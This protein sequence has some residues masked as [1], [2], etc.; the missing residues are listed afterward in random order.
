MSTDIKSQVVQQIKDA[1]FGLFAIQMDESTD[2]SFCAQLMVFV[3]Y[4][5]NGAFKEEFLFCSGL[6]TNT[7]ATNIF[8]KA[9][10]FFESEDLERQNLV[11]CCTDGAPA[12]LGCH[13]GFQTLVKQ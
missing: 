2:V 6:E 8:E 5:Y 12:M 10:S 11:G 4:I 1:C 3:K 7:K 13:S 9:S